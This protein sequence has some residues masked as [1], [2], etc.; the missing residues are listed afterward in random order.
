MR[1]AAM[2]RASPHPHPAHPRPCRCAALGLLALALAAPAG[3]EQPL[4]E[5]GLGVAGLSVPHYRGSDQVHQWL[6]PVPFGVYRGDIL[7]ATRDGA[8]AVLL[9]TER[10]DFDISVSASPPT[11]S[12]DN[13]ARSGMPDLD[14]AAEIGPN[15]KL[16]LARGAGWELQLQLPLRAVFTLGSDMHGIGWTATPALDLDLEIRGWDIAVRA[17][18]LA[19]TRDH[20]AYYY[21]VPPAY[22][23]AERPAYSAPGGAAGWAL[24]LGASRRFGLLWVGGFLS[25]DDV[26]GAAFEASPLVRQRRSLTAGLALSWVLLTS[27][28]RVA[29]DR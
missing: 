6:L 19:A 27:Q 25:S 7:R 13:D 10:V 1:Q 2:T 20:H 22:A 4:W 14:A 12:S 29:G 26:S 9:E 16:K 3:A 28:T 18:G 8:R 15:L 24:R 5:L 17:E 23:T 11:R 21:D